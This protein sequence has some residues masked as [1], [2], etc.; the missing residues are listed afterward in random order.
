M[1]SIEDLE[2]LRKLYDIICASDTSG[3][4]ASWM[5]ELKRAYIYYG[6]SND[7]GRAMQNMITLLL[8]YIP[9]HSSLTPFLTD[10]SMHFPQ[11]LDSL[12]W[13]E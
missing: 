13:Q 8:Y 11:I 9:R 7:S 3:T 1:E 5:N 2:K 12:R 6:L 10:D 4:H